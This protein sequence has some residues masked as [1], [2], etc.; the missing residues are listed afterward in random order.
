[1]SELNESKTARI[2]LTE[3]MPVAS[4]ILAGIVFLL[5]AVS[6]IANGSFSLWGALYLL[7]FSL[8]LLG[9]ILHK[10]NLQ[11]LTAIGCFLF[12]VSN[13]IGLATFYYNFISFFQ[14]VNLLLYLFCTAGYTV[15]GLYY[16]TKKPVLGM[17]LKMILMIII[18]ALCTLRILPLLH[19]ML[20]I[21]GYPP[22][23]IMG[24][25]IDLLSALSVMLY[26]PFRKA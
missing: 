10:K 5:D 15:A 18:M 6:R 20:S 22:A 14:V 25:V 12:A 21:P 8:I 2:R 4:T 23:I 13:I 16:I 3:K 7:S 11:L 26:T 1:M 24:V 9:L 17:P 19:A